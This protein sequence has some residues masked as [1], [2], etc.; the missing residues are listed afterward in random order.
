M[1]LRGARQV[2][3]TTLIRI[4]AKELGLTLIEVNLEDRPSFAGMLDKRSNAKDILELLLL[5][6]GVT[7]EPEK[8]LFFFDEIQELPGF[9][10]Y[11]RYFKE[12][13]QEYKVIT[14]GSLLEL[15]IQK[16]KRGQG[17]SGRVEFA[18]LDPMTFEEFVLAANPVAHKKLTN[19]DVLE[20]IGSRFHEIFYSLYKQYMVCGGMPAVVEAFVNNEGVLRVDEIKNNLLTGYINDFADFGKLSGQKYAPE[21]LELIFRQV[22]SHPCNSMTLSKLAPGFRAEKIRDHIEIL[23]K[24]K[25]IRRSVHTHENKA[26]LL[27]GADKYAHKLFALDIGLCYSYMELLP[28]E[29]YGS[30]DINSVA[31]GALAEQFVAQTLQS[32]PPYYKAKS[33]YHWE[34]KKKNAISEVDFVA[35]L[36]SRVV[37]IECK[38]GHSNKMISLKL[39]LGAKTY[40]MALRLYAGDIEYG[41][42]KPRA[43]QAD[44]KEVPLVSMPHYML[45]QFVSK[46]SNISAKVMP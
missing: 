2:G 33:L 7:A 15:E 35:A 23:V 42:I 36:D 14:A 46:C 21:L 4:L 24:S 31:E 6:K 38:S 45:E 26:P 3:K 44:L 1:V 16:E 9:Y 11:L 28:Q 22:Y 12:L 30:A 10:E 17:P 27:S 43:E 34:R 40:P 19:L 29:V 25:L 41:L 32:L 8:V 39:M 18:Y 20:P 5:E 37:P 13:A